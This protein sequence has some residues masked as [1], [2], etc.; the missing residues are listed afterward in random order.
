M[1]GLGEG[2][3]P[4]DVN[5]LIYGNVAAVFHRGNSPLPIPADEGSGEGRKEC[6]LP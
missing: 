6:I 3:K 2:V 5:F 1:F 4:Q